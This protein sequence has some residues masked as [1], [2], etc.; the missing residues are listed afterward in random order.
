MAGETQGRMDQ[1]SCR[2]I[3]SSWDLQLFKVRLFIYSLRDTFLPI[4]FSVSLSLLSYFQSLSYFP[5]TFHLCDSP[6]WKIRAALTVAGSRAPGEC[7]PPTDRSRPAWSEDRLTMSSSRFLPLSLLFSLAFLLFL[8][9]SPWCGSHLIKTCSVPALFK[10]SLEFKLY[11][12][13]KREK[14][15]KKPVSNFTLSEKFRHFVSTK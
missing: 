10:M 7:L 3:T 2:F 13:G 4:L 11:D 8:S 9:D 15:K 14:R 6:S 12:R 1:F 5:V